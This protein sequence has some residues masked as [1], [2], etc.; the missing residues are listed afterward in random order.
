MIAMIEYGL[1]HKVKYPGEE[2]FAY[3]V[4]KA[5]AYLDK[6]RAVVEVPERAEE[7][8]KMTPSQLD[9]RIHEEYNVPIEGLEMLNP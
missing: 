1:E 3:A 7:C 9:Q 4:K 5:L 8:L 6:N 2:G